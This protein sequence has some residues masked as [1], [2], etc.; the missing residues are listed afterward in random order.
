MNNKL[1]KEKPMDITK[2]LQYFEYPCSESKHIRVYSPEEQGYKNLVM[3]AMMLT[4]Q[5]SAHFFVHNTMY[6][7]NWEAS[8]IVRSVQ[9]PNDKED[10]KIY[11]V[12]H[13]EAYKKVVEATSVV[14][15]AKA[16]ENCGEN[17]CTATKELNNEDRIVNRLIRPNN[18]NSGNPIKVGDWIDTPRFCGVR[19]KEVFDSL[20]EAESNGYKEPTYYDTGNGYGITGKSLDQYHMVFA[21]YKI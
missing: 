2:N 17:L 9:N 8:L 12:L 4:F 11:Q 16:I 10:Y 19:I 3:A 1:T 5:Y 7:P 14:E 6:Q 15:I 20:E 13:P 18:T 21:A